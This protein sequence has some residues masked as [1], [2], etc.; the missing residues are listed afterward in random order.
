MESLSDL[1]IVRD[2]MKLDAGILGTSLTFC[3][4]SYLIFVARQRYFPNFIPPKIP[5]RS[6]IGVISMPE[7][8]LFQVL[9]FT[10]SQTPGGHVKNYKPRKWHRK[11][12]KGCM[13]CKRR[14]IRVSA[15]S[16]KS[17]AVLAECRSAMNK[18]RRARTAS[19]MV[20]AVAIMPYFRLE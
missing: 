10:E 19:S 15:S 13:I 18:R 1:C 2:R 9:S 8:G 16:I 4:D 14:R 11:S 6:L 7:G 20:R 3:F 12:Q 5:P 17:K